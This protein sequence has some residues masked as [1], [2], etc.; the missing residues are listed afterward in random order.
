MTDKDKTRGSVK[1]GLG[2]VKEGAGRA[3][4][5]REMEAEGNAD[6]VEGK[7]QKNVGKVKDAVRDQLR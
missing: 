2:K 5:D 7:T 6:R 4:G 1:E 3:L